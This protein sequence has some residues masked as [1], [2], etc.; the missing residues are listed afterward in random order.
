MP[1]TGLDAMD[2]TGTQREIQA[3]YWKDG[4]KKEKGGGRGGAGE[5]GT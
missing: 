1:D 4:D 5:I 2:L 3:F